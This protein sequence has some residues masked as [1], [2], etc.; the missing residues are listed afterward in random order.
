MRDLNR[1]AIAGKVTIR[2]LEPGEFRP[3]TGAEVKWLF[4][5]SS[6]EYHSQ[7][8]AATQAWL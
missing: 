7:E 8:R 5:A 2:G 1:V 3:L 4:H 6:P